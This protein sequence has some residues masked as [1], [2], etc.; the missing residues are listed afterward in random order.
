MSVQ[1]AL[2]GADVLLP[3]GLPAPGLA[4]LL[5]AH[6]SKVVGSTPAAAA[7]SAQPAALAGDSVALADALRAL[8]FPTLRLLR[9]SLADFRPSEA[10]T[11]MED[12]VAYLRVESWWVLGCAGRALTVHRLF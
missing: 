9:L 5:A 6:A 8:G 4:P 11:E 10:G 2:S 3:L 12:S 7:T 1:A